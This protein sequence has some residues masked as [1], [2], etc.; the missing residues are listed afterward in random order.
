LFVVH[1]RLRET[2][3]GGL[4][5]VGDLERL[6]VRAAL[7]EATPRDL[8]G[9]R[10]GLTAAGHA[11]RSMEEVRDS[12]LREVLGL[13]KVDIDTVPELARELTEAL[14]ERPSP[15]AKQG[16]IFKREFDR[17]LSELDALRRTGTE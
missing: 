4:D 12:D 13:Q 8:A 6:S 9:L 11:V 1:A 10:D 17:E 2:L 5:G 15:L 16:E 14:A 3:R 7:G